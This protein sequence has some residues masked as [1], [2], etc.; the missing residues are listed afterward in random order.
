MGGEEGRE[1][2][3]DGGNKESDAEEGGLKVV[4]PQDRFVNSFPVPLSN[5]RFAAG[6]LA[7]P[8]GIDRPKC[9]IGPVRA[10]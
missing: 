1:H 3:R 10:R 6:G 9:I 8:R 7:R 4:I 2:W 5:R